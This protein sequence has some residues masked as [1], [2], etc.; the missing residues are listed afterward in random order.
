MKKCKLKLLTKILAI[1]IICLVSFLGV[2]VQKQNRM[3]N[4]IKGYDLTKDLSGYRQIIFELSEAKEV[5]DK[6]GKVIGNT[7]EYDDETIKNNSYKKSKT[8]VNAEEKLK[9]ENYLESKKILEKRLDIIGMEDYNLSLDKKTGKLYLQIPEDDNTDY[10]VSNIL[11]TGSFEIK[12][13]EDNTKYITSKNLKK[14]NVFY[15]STET[16]TLV[17]IGMQLDKDGTAILEDLSTNKYAKLDEVQ[18]ENATVEEEK[19]K[20]ENKEEK[21]EKEEV[22]QKEVTIS[23]NGMEMDT[24]SYEEPIRDGFIGYSVGRATTDDKSLQ[25]SI[26]VASTYVMLLESGELPIVYKVTQNQ[27]VTTDISSEVI[28][29]TVILAGTVLAILLVFMIIKNKLRGLLGVITYMGFIALYLLL[30]RYTNVAISISGIIAI[31]LICII[32]Y[33]ATMKLISIKNDNKLYRQEYFKVM[34]KII[35][36][37][38]ISII[39]IFAKWVTLSSFGML[40]FWGIG[41]MMLYNILVTKNIVD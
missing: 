24:T 18:E 35:P 40:L 19:N 2:Y 16:G 4:V 5:L 33:L 15:Q 10:V 17:C 8:K 27:Y 20:K 39:F 21:T 29:N 9:V 32:N 34:A 28:R 38:I 6:D 11:G 3:E 23:I 13:S 14:T 36:L 31:G 37:L 7:D 12:D 30:I 1:V 41:L 26:R 22:K 25:E